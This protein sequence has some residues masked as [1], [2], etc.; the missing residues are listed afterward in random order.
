MMYSSHCPVRSWGSLLRSPW[1]M[2]ACWAP[3]DCNVVDTL[4]GVGVDDGDG[5]DGSC[6]M[7]RPGVSSSVAECGRSVSAVRMEALVT[8]EGLI[9]LMS[10]IGGPGGPSSESSS[11]RPR[12]DPRALR[13]S[14]LRRLLD[15]CLSSDGDSRSSWATTAAPPSAAPAAAI[16]F[17]RSA[18]RIGVSSRSCSSSI[19]S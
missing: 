11:S 17:S 4:V 10:G 19:E 5:E 9:S 14:A 7:S 3:S 15:R 16:D 8:S 6:G 2:L 1:E 18:L 12:S 13:I